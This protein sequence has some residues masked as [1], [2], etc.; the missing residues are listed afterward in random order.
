MGKKKSDFKKTMVKKG[1][2]DGLRAIT[3]EQDWFKT[4]QPD[5]YEQTTFD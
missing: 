5:K 4:T 3:K 1:K 2:D